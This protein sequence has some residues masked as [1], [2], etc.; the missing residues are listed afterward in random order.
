MLTYNWQVQLQS[1][2]L[3]KLEPV[4]VCRPT[5]GTHAINGDVVK[6]SRLL[7]THIPGQ[8]TAIAT[9]R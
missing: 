8:A 3:K 2:G 1:N 7:S 6:Q 5:Q 9:Y 4:H